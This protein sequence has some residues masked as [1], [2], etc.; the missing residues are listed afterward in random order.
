MIYNDFVKFK[1]EKEKEDSIIKN[2]DL[3]EHKAKNILSSE[4][5][6]ISES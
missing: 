5:S 6:S 4:D 3:F 2:E 1:I